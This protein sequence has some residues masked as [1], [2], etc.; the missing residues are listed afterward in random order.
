MYVYLKVRNAPSY[1]AEFD[2]TSRKHT[3]E[4]TREFHARWTADEFLSLTQGIRRDAQQHL[5]HNLIKHRYIGRAPTYIY[6]QRS[7]SEELATRL[8]DNAEM[9]TPL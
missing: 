8:T 7:P 3:T 1:H 4:R 9:V 6:A 2:G 5:R